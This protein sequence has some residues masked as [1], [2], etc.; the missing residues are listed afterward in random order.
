LRPLLLWDL[1]RP[2]LLLLLWDLL[3]PLPL[4]RL[5]LLL[6]PLNLFCLYVPFGRCDHGGLFFHV[7]LYGS[8]VYDKVFENNS[9]SK[10]IFCKDLC[11]LLVM[12]EESDETL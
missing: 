9:I 5:S 10:Q 2:L 4:L 6:P 8:G 12:L 11:F 3:L 7:Y 1:L